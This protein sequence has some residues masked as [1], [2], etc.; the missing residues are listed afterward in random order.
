MNK[1]PTIVHVTHEAAGKIGGIG[2]VLEGLFTA[3]AYREATGRTILISPLF[4]AD[5]DISERLGPGGEVLYSS[6]DGRTRGGYAA[7]FQKIEM[8]YNFGIVYGRRTFMDPLTK[9]KS[10]PGCC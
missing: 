4:S 3:K 5:G 2:A 7:G 6:I 8:K 9:I 1:Q 10:S